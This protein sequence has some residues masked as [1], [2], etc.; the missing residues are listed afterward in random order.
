V[1]VSGPQ[2]LDMGVVV[3][4]SGLSSPWSNSSGQPFDGLRVSGEGPRAEVRCKRAEPQRS[5]PQNCREAGT[6]SG[7]RHEGNTQQKIES[8]MEG[9]RADGMSNHGCLAGGGGDGSGLEAT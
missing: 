1:V 3:L 7:P 6:A 2:T 4:E 5:E 8:G 9:L